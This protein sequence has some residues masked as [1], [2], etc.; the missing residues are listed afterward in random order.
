M[1]NKLKEIA[2]AL[3]LGT[4]YSAVIFLG[5]VLFKFLLDTLP[6]EV[7]L[8]LLVLAMSTVF[9]VTR[10]KGSFDE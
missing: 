8:L 9:Y 3:A 1:V 7:T 5:I 4:T 2:T 10:T 6:P